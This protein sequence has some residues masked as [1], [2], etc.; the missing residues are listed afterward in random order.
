MNDSKV[1]SHE[2]QIQSE[3]TLIEKE[4]LY[5]P[6]NIFKA[7][8]IFLS[9]ISMYLK[10]LSVLLLIIL[11]NPKI[12]IGEI[13]AEPLKVHGLYKNARERKNRV[14]ELLIQVGLNEE[15]A[16]RNREIRMTLID[17]ISNT[18]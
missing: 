10:S 9:K 6:F 16:A 7:C 1:L 12:S 18:P 2:I 14:L 11:L 17:F 4:S 3:N 8:V 13:I 5:C 15:H